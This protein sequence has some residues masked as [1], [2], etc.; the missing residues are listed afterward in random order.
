M[1]PENTLAVAGVCDVL[2]FRC[3]L[4]LSLQRL[5]AELFSLCLAFDRSA[6]SRSCTARSGGGGSGW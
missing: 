5:L 3:L 2:V 1:L 4:A 6:A